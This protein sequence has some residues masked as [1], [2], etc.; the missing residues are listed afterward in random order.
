MEFKISRITGVVIGI[1][2]ASMP[3]SGWADELSLSLRERAFADCFHEDN[4]RRTFYRARLDGMDVTIDEVRD[5]MSR[6]GEADAHAI[7]GVYIWGL[8]DES[9]SRERLRETVDFHNSEG[10]SELAGCLNHAGRAY[11]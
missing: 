8:S 11:P 7:G 2:L 1:S 4:I 6:L 10:N 3:F 5:V 9:Y